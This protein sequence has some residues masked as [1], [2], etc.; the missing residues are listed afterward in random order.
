MQRSNA[1][2]PLVL[3]YCSSSQTRLICHT[4]CLYGFFLIGYSYFS[5]SL[6]NSKLHTLLQCKVLMKSQWIKQKKA[7]FVSCAAGRWVS[8]GT[9]TSLETLHHPSIYKFTCKHR[10]SRL[11]LDWGISC[12]PCFMVKLLRTCT[13]HL[14]SI[15]AHNFN[16]GHSTCLSWLSCSGGTSSHVAFGDKWVS[17][18][19]SPWCYT[20]TFIP[21]LIL[22]GLELLLLLSVLHLKCHGLATKGQGNP[23]SC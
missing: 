21:H 23:D 18:C 20:E 6:T 8:G 17:V 19:S 14:G 7:S 3:C 13:S 16:F 2:T 4:A 5:L 10:E 9:G 15:R 1:V 22:Y 12:F 11:I